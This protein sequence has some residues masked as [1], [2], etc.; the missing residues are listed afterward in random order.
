MINPENR[1]LY[2]LGLLA[3]LF[4]AFLMIQALLP[5]L[6]ALALGIATSLAWKQRRS[7]TRTEESQLNKIFYDLLRQHEGRI[8]V[9][10]FAMTA[11]LNPQ[12][13]KAYLNIRAKEFSALF[14][15]TDYGDVLYRFYSLTIPAP[16]SSQPEQPQTTTMLEPDLSLALSPAALARRL[17]LSVEIIHR[18]KQTPDFWTGLNA[19]I[20]KALAGATPSAI[21]V[22]TQS[23]L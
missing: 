17:D 21:A 23:K 2:S 1:F 19:K 5:W 22:F 6:L 20:H 7:Q 8:S 18:R 15:P 9:L 13:A 12:D 10:D 16:P 3:L 4:L 11:N 14:E